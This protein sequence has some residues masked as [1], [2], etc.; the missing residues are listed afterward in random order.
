MALECYL[1]GSMATL[2][3][4]FLWTRYKT[5]FPAEPTVIP[6]HAVSYPSPSLIG[7]YLCR[8]FQEKEAD[9]KGVSMMADE[10][11]RDFQLPLLGS[12]VI[13]R[14]WKSSFSLKVFIKIS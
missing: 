6:V 14:L 8:V 7:I 11:F 10:S 12:G 1:R 13:R 5:D 2:M 4:K 3:S 9:Q